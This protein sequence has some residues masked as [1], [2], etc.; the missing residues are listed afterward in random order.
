M[1]RNVL[2]SDTNNKIIF[3]IN[4]CLFTEEAEAAAA[5]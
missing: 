4:I 1:N 2:N 5:K 3:D